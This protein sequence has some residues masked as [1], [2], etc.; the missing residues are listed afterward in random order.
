MGDGRNRGPR[1]VTPAA[2]ARRPDTRCTRLAIVG[3]GGA[4]V[5]TLAWLAEAGGIEARLIAVDACAAT[6]GGVPDNGGPPWRPAAP[7]CIQLPRSTGGRTTPDARADAARSIEPVLRAAVLDADLVFVVAG[8]SGDTGGGVAPVVAELAK[9]GGA[10]VVGFGLAPFP[11]EPERNHQ[12]AATAEARLLSACDAVVTLDGD[13]AFGVVG[14]DLPLEWAAAAA[15]EVVRQTA[16][17]IAAFADAGGCLKIGLP[18]LVRLFGNGG[19]SCVATGTAAPRA[20]EDRNSS[21]PAWLGA[22]SPAERAVTA[23]LDSPFTDLAAIA[24]ADRV[25]CQITAGPDLALADV[26]AAIERLHGAIR[27][28]CDVRVGVLSGALLPGSARVLVIGTAVPERSGANVVPFSREPLSPRAAIGRAD[29]DGVCAQ[30]DGAAGAIGVV[31][32]RPV[33][34][35]A[36]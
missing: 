36:G 16:V 25:L 10:L 13:L 18:D 26:D 35:A 22:L 14:A 28:G 11:F 19:R 12:A 8:L 17:G 20:V 1:P 15:R 32:E 30:A 27:P 3:V 23:A 5:A 6:L 7:I 34:A 2:V 4:G 33:R 21:T 29:R 24:T 9:A 31:R